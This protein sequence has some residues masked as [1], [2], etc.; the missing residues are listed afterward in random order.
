VVPIEARLESEGGT[1]VTI[2]DPNGGTCD[3]AGG[4]DRVLPLDNPS[5]RCLGVV[6]PYGD[7]VFNRL[8]MPFLLDDIARLDL[9]SATDLERRGVLR[10]EAMARRCMEETHIYLRFIGD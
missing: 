4:F 2:A 9:A 1:V 3:G 10:L 8:Q 6:D 7:T 5:F